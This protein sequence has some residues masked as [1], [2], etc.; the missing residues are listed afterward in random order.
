MLISRTR[1]T[2]WGK[3]FYAAFVNIRCQEIALSVCQAESQR[4]KKEWCRGYDVAEHTTEGRRVSAAQQWKDARMSEPPP[5]CHTP[6]VTDAQCVLVP[7]ELGVH[8]FKKRLCPH[9]GQLVMFYLSLRFS[10]LSSC[11]INSGQQRF[12]F[13]CL[14]AQYAERHLSCPYYL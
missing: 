9:V 13:S 4:D 12:T 8:V 6:C 10:S 11:L 14:S 1:G 2:V 5:I 3:D 7:C